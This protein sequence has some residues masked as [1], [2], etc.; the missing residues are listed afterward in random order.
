MFGKVSNVVNYVDRV[1]SI[2]LYNNIVSVSLTG[3]EVEFKER[4]YTVGVVRP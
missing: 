3:M 4:S 2:H 1:S